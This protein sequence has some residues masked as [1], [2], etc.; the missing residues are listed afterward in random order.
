LSA[1]CA[2]K[3]SIYNLSALQEGLQLARRKSIYEELH[4]E[5]KHGGDR[6]SEEAKSNGNNFHLIPSF[7]EDAAQK[8]GKTDRTIRIKRAGLMHLD[9]IPQTLHA[10]GSFD[11]TGSDLPNEPSDDT[12]RGRSPHALGGWRGLV[13]R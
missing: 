9:K 4:P 3:K 5:T 11:R 6:K 1:H 13:K 2:A 10:F 12:R 8:T 7:A